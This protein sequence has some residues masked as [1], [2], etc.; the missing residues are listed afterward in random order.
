MDEESTDVP[1]TA[2]TYLISEVLSGRFTS[3]ALQAFMRNVN[4]NTPIP[5]ALLHDGLS[6]SQLGLLEDRRQVGLR[7]YDN[8]QL[9]SLAFLQ[10]SCGYAHGNYYE[11]KPFIEGKFDELVRLA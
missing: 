1:Y 9:F 3:T 10:R 5:E 4:T 7:Q 11:Y 8:A 2:R 6:Y